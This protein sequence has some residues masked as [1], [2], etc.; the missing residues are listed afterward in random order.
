MDRPQS[1]LFAQAGGT[2]Q[3]GPAICYLCGRAC[4][5]T[6]PVGNGIAETFNSH[7]LARCRSSA[8]LCAACAW[9]L[10]G[11][12]D[13]P[14][15]R[16]MSLVVSP[17]SYR[18]WQRADMKADL[19]RWLVAGLEEDCYL[20]VSLTKK[21]HLLLQA[22][23]NARGARTLAIQVEEKLA[24]VDAASLAAVEQPFL[25]LLALGHAKGEILSGELFTSVL[26]KHGRLREAL[27]WSKQL[28]RWRSSA[29][30]ELYSYTT[31][32]D[33]QDKKGPLDDDES[34]PGGRSVAGSTGG[35]AGGDA[36]AHGGVSSTF[37][38]LEVGRPRLQ[39]DIPGGNLATI[40]GA[41][42]DCCADDGNAPGI[43]QPAL[44]DASDCEP[45][46]R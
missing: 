31:I 15:F 18:V 42:C 21:K 45:G 7:W 24:Y 10:D 38:D 44:W 4:G 43:S 13:H 8:W 5:M 30:L 46:D 40:R 26:R 6:Y 2:V 41:H 20:V 16:K 22:P 9:Y 33:E 23:P 19:A 28:E 39:S 34:G 25:A 14:D 32:L 17:S 1:W 37:C 29:L 3:E 35:S 12:A 27:H 11:K 36:P